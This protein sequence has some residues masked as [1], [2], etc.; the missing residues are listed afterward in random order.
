MKHYAFLLLS[1]LLWG[2]LVLV[3]CG[4]D[5]HHFKIAGRFL[6]LNQGEFYVY[7]LDGGNSNIDTIKVQGGRFSREIECTDP[8]TLM[9]VFPNFSEQPVFAEPGK[10]VDIRANAANLKEMEVSGTDENEQ[11]TT[12]R[13]RI[14]NVSPPEAR[15]QAAAFI[16][17]NPRSPVSVFL[18]RK[19]F[20]MAQQPD[21][22]QAKLLIEPMMKEMADNK[23]PAFSGSL[24]SISKKLEALSNAEENTSL[25]RFAAT[26]SKG[27]VISTENFKGKTGLIYV[28]ATWNYESMS[29][30]RRLK[31]IQRKNPTQLQIMGI[32]I[33]A[34]PR[35]CNTNADRDTLTWPHICDGQLF[36]GPLI[37]KLGIRG[38][39]DNIIISKSGRITAH[40]L[41]TQQMIDELNRQ[42]QK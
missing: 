2:A 42:L 7:A 34:T 39:G 40:G 9:L 12:F 14:A 3:S 27:R 8:Q 31:A 18:L 36:N 24:L 30:Q 26:D 35:D 1:S 15:Q 20:I 4:T 16:K 33:E 29:M 41:P 17:A 10:S 25:P 23:N 22:K 13:K 5:S 37:S 19:F 38:I 28:W 32:C 6:N 21:Y 11:M